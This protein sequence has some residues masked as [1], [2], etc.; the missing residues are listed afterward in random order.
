M[1]ITLNSKQNRQKPHIL[2][3]GTS[4]NQLEPGGTNWDHL[5]RD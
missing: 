3:Q 4:W 1:K 2:K 5:E